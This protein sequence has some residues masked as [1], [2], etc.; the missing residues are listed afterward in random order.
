MAASAPSLSDHSSRAF[1]PAV[2][3][4]LTA[5]STSVTSCPRAFSAAVNCDW[6]PS[7]AAS[8]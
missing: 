8:P 1:P 3:S 2:V 5:A 6:N 4:P 7:A